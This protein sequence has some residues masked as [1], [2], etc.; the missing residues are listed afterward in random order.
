M[1]GTD[2][3]KAVIIC[4]DLDATSFQS[5]TILPPVA[6]LLERAAGRT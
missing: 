2:G 3:A 5:N 6:S 4:F 1:A